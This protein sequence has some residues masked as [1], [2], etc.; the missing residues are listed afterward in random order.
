MLHAVRLNSV[1]MDLLCVERAWVLGSSGFWLLPVIYLVYL[2]SFANY[3]HVIGLIALTLASFFY[4]L[5]SHDDH[6][7]CAHT[8][9]ASYDTLYLGY[10][11]FAVLVL[12]QTWCYRLAYE[13]RFLRQLPGFMLPIIACIYLNYLPVDDVDY[14]KQTRVLVITVIVILAIITLIRFFFRSTK[15]QHSWWFLPLT[16]RTSIYLFGFVAS[17]VGVWL[18]Q[19]FEYTD[20]TNNYRH[21]HPVFTIVAAVAVTTLLM[22]IENEHQLAPGAKLDK[23]TDP[24][25]A[26]LNTMKNKF[27]MMAV[28]TDDSV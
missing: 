7:S 10:I 24:L 12:I 1:I 11:S 8:C 21:L 2:R 27:V 26:T 3:V 19:Y 16:K 23:F 17:V 20:N 22:Y 5:C 25:Q 14:Q 28:S 4:S 13:I 15:P 6:L 18:I 9:I